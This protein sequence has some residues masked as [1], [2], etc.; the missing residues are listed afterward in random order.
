[1]ALDLQEIQYVNRGKLCG[2]GAP[3]PD[4]AESESR[5]VGSVDRRGALDRAK[6]NPRAGYLCGN[7]HRG[8][9]WLVVVLRVVSAPPS[10]LINLRTFSPDIF[11]KIR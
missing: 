5:H 4:K 11:G 2:S 1:M 7:H 9:A 6:T 3:G 10:T 8:N